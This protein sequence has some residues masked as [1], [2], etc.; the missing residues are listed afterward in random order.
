MNVLFACVTNA[1]RSSIAKALFGLV[2]GGAHVDDA[3]ATDDAR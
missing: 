2:A 3:E 1:G